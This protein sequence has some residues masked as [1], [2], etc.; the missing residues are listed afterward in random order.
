MRWV[1]PR[2]ARGIHLH[3]FQRARFPHNHM[4]CWDRPPLRSS[5]QVPVPHHEA[6][7]LW[8]TTTMKMMRGEPAVAGE[9]PAAGPP[10]GPPPPSHDEVLSVGPLPI[11]IIG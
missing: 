8:R 4:G 7:G 11:I 5:S 2:G 1:A 3:I 10:P 6:T 9:K